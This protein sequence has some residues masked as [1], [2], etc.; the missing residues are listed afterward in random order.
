MVTRW[1]IDG[2]DTLRGRG[3]STEEL[4]AETSRNVLDSRPNA[5]RLVD[6]FVEHCMTSL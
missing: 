4:R 1:A 2:G 6:W 5:E 3:T